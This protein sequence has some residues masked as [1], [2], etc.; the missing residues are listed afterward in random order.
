MPVTKAQTRYDY[1]THA[2]HDGASEPGADLL[3]VSQTCQ[4]CSTYRGLRSQPDLYFVCASS[5]C[6]SLVCAVWGEQ[7]SRTRTTRTHTH[8]H[9]SNRNVVLQCLSNSPILRLGVAELARRG[10]LK[11]ITET[12]ELA[13]SKQHVRLLLKRRST[14][15]CRELIERKPEI[16]GRRVARRSNAVERPPEPPDMCFALHSLFR[17]MVSSRRPSVNIGSHGSSPIRRILAAC[18][19]VPRAAPASMHPCCVSNFQRPICRMSV[20]P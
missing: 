11:S 8:V 2:R 19:H 20:I 17:V 14:I 13:K 1:V 9:S 15:E 5:S 18:L 7:R 4:H 6:C 12:L 3:H 16:L 10:I